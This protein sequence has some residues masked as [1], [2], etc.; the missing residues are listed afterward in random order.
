MHQRVTAQC[1]LSELG[2]TLLAGIC[3]KFRSKHT[4]HESSAAVFLT[5]SFGFA[6][7]FFFCPR[8][9]RISVRVC[10]WLCTLPCKATASMLRVHLVPTASSAKDLISSQ[11]QVSIAAK[12]VNA[13]TF[14]FRLWYPAQCTKVTSVN[15][16]VHR[17]CFYT[18]RNDA[19]ELNTRYTWFLHVASRNPA[20][21]S[22]AFQKFSSQA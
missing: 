1:T 6:F 9:R 13:C 10:L 8:V 4:L 12:A 21:S 11:S 20:L 2:Y 7:V 16:L 15:V 3:A 5:S 14:S 17:C 18:R 19:R 22:L